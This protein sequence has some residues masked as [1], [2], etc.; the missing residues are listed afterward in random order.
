MAAFFITAAGGK[1]IGKLKE[2]SESNPSL[3]SDPN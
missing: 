3:P 1:N 2:D